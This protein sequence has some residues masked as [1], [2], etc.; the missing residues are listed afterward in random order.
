LS[1]GLWFAGEID[2]NLFSSNEGIGGG[3][4]LVGVAGLNFFKGEL[5]CLEED[6]EGLSL[7]SSI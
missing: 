4:S 2:P 7:S 1:A 6:T 5:L 3:G